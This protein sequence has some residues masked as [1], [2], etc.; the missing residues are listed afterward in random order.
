MVE[1][2]LGQRLQEHFKVPVV[3]TN[4]ASLIALAEHRYG[5]AKGVSSLFCF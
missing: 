4:N 2:P 3:V 5:Q 1:F